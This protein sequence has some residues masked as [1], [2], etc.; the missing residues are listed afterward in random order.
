MRMEQYCGELE[1]YYPIRS[2]NGIPVYTDKDL[3]GLVW[4]PIMGVKI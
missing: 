2:I 4:Y 3:E 1:G